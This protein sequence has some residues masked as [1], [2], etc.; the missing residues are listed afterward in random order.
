MQL[1]LGRPLWRQRASWDSAGWSRLS[2]AKRADGAWLA[3]GARGQG[4]AGEVEGPCLQSPLSPQRPSAGSIPCEA[5]MLRR[6]LLPLP[7][8]C[9]LQ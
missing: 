2:I 5:M 1:D 3:G 7:L 4:Q 9:L 6:P 8:M